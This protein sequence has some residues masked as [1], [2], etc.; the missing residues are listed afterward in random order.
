MKTATS[1]LV[2]TAPEPRFGIS[3]ASPDQVPLPLAGIS[4]LRLTSTSG[5][6]KGNPIQERA[7]HFMQVLV[8]VLAGERPS[9]QLGIW[10]SPDVYEQLQRKLQSSSRGPQRSRISA[11][12][13]IVSV[14]VAMVSDSSA[15]ISARMSQG[16]RSRA[17]A[18]RLELHASMRGPRQWRCTALI[19]A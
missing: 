15:E 5:G 16:G 4:Q 17:L 2:R 11:G 10:M 6:Q 8:E 18:V 14:H 1:L 13:R 9:R 3:S 19:W 7:A 12:T